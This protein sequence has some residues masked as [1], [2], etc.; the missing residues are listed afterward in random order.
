MSYEVQAA[1]D[2]VW[3]CEQSGV[4]TPDADRQHIR[5]LAAEVLRLR[6]ISTAATTELRMILD[7]I[8]AAQPTPSE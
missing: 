2:Y 1:L 4:H 7:R 5:V 3:R 8:G 6:N